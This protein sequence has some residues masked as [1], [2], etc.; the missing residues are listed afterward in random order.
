MRNLLRHM[1]LVCLLVPCLA[2]Q[3]QSRNPYDLELTRLQA[4]WSAAGKLEKLV[5]FD[6]ILHLRDFVDDRSRVQQ[7]LENIRQSPAEDAL[8]KT[9]AAA[10]LA[11]RRGFTLAS[12]PRTQH[13]YA[14]AESRKR[15]LAKA[16][17]AINSGSA[18]DLQL[19]AEFEHLAGATEATDRIFQAAQ[20]EPTAMRWQLVAEFTD[21]PL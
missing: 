13:W 12:H 19:L 8:V 14:T 18:A 17:Q 16:R 1:P 11:D 20:L 9:E 3:A 21:E 7:F 15:V 4:K 6:R 5:L 10:S 2:L